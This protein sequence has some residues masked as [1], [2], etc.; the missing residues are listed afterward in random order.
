M[1]MLWSAIV[2]LGEQGRPEPRHRGRGVEAGVDE[3]GQRGGREALRNVHRGYFLEPVQGINAPLGVD[4]PAGSLQERRGGAVE[5][6]DA[7][8][9]ERQQ[10]VIRQWLGAGI[11]EALAR[12]DFADRAPDPFGSDFDDTSTDS[13]TA[14]TSAERVG[15]LRLDS[16]SAVGGHGWASGP[17]RFHSVTNSATAAA[18]WA[19]E[20][21]SPIDEISGVDSSARTLA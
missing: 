5:L 11:G 21:A 6:V 10:G 13:D 7:P 9:A 8:A 15:G 3:R 20:S 18:T 17:S 1:S 2:V 12:E 19:V 4:R 16:A 14:S